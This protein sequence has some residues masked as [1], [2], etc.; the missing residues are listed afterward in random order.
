[1]YYA[2]M[3][4]CQYGHTKNWCKTK[5]EPI[6]KNSGKEKHE[7]CKPPNDKHGSFDK[8]CL[9]D[10]GIS[11]GMGRKIFEEKIQASN[12]HMLKLLA[13]SSMTSPNMRQM[14]CKLY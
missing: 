1:M 8:D 12:K 6:C 13:S 5:K 9:I 2:G 3:K 10:R 14:N 7:N 4:G 11:Y